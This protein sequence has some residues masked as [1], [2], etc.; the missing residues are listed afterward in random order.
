MCLNTIRGTDGGDWIISL[1]ADGLWLRVTGNNQWDP[2]LNMVDDFS[3]YMEWGTSIGPNVSDTRLY[4]S[5]VL[6]TSL[7]GND[8][9]I[10]TESSPSSNFGGAVQNDSTIG[11][12]GRM[13][14]FF[15]IDTLLSSSDRAI[16][17]QFMRDSA[18]IT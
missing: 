15:L 17:D 3:L 5:N 4:K 18:G 6:V 9:S 7:G 2:W 1:E 8:K 11:F 13:Y 12:N 10:N 14:G 16:V